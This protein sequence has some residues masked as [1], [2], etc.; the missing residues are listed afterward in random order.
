MIAMG[1]NLVELSG[2]E[3]MFPSVSNAGNVACSL[4]GMGQGITIISAGETS[5]LRRIRCV[6][7]DADRCRS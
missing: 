2:I 1:R 6:I 5:G 3:L 4:S 7:P